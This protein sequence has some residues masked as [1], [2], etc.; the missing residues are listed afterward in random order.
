MEQ[1]LWFLSMGARAKQCPHSVET[2]GQS[3]RLLR[4][5]S[6]TLETT[7]G[8][9]N[10]TL[11]YMGRA[12]ATQTVLWYNGSLLSCAICY[13]LRT[14][15]MYYMNPTAAPFNGIT[16]NIISYNILAPNWIWPGCNSS[17]R[18]LAGTSPG[19]SK[20]ENPH[21]LSISGSYLREINPYTGAL[22]GNY[23][24]SPLSGGTYYKNQWVLNIQDL[25][26]AAAM[27]PVGVTV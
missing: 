1:Q 10:P 7:G 4:A 5:R 12:Y 14:G 21:L 3:R 17:A 19:E 26:A 8:A 13:D 16:P 6:I 15:E 2:T 25:G 23:S 18:R 27:Q 11:V 22:T 9:T 20:V 24:I